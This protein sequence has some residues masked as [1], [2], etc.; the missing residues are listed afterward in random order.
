MFSISCLC[1]FVIR[2]MP[3]CELFL[4]EIGVLGGVP[5]DC[6]MPDVDRDAK[7]SYARVR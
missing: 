1:N 2:F 5:L 6:Y 7:G 4:Q 3:E